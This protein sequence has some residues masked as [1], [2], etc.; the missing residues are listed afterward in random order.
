MKL[1]I[2]WNAIKASRNEEK[3]GVTFEE[4]LTVF[5][6][7]FS[8]TV[9][10]PFHS[11]SEQR[12]ATIGTSSYNRLLVVVHTDRGE[13]IRIISARKATKNE[14]LQYEEVG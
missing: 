1:R 8:V 4:A 12:F 3:H 5:N 6:D 10:D 2:E 11:T 9:E 14:R 7:I 13:R